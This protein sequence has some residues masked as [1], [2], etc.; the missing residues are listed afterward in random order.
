MRNI[1][2]LSLLLLVSCGKTVENKVT[3]ILNAKS[4]SVELSD[5]NGTL[6]LDRVD[7]KAAYLAVAPER[8]VGSFD[9]KKLKEEWD[10]AFKQ[11]S[12]NAVVIFW[13]DGVEQ[14]I[15]LDLKSYVVSEDGTMVFKVHALSSD[16]K[17]FKEMFEEN[18]LFID[19]SK[20]DAFLFRIR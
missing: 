13:K 10:K 2:L 17:D 16:H 20:K 5:G 8:Q 14:K 11:S 6:K 3:I 9:V 7:E 12:P 15:A 19:Y 1:L 18:S 4:G